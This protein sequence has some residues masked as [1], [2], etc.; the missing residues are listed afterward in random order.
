LVPSRCCFGSKNPSKKKTPIIM[1]GTAIGTPK[2]A[3]IQEPIVTSQFSQALILQ[4]DP[5]I[6]V[7]NKDS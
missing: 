5:S 1:P 7:G 6:P 3:E 2:G 4:K